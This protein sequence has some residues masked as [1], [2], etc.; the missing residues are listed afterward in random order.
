MVFVDDICTQ[1]VMRRTQQEQV[2]MNE[3]YRDFFGSAGCIVKFSNEIYATKF[4]AGIFPALI[5]LGRQVPIGEFNRCL[6]AKG[7]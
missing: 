5:E 6:G 1:L 4:S 3:Q 2:R 7:G